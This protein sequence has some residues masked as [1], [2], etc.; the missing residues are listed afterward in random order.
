M[1]NFLPKLETALKNGAVVVIGYRGIKN[2]LVDALDSLNAARAEV[3][4]RAKS[5]LPKTQE[6]LH[7]SEE[8][9]RHAVVLLGII[10]VGDRLYVLVQDST[11]G[12]GFRSDGFRE[13]QPR[14]WPLE[15]LNRPSVVGAYIISN[16]KLKH[17]K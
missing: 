17:R 16:P 7:S 6:Q 1:P 5:M 3:Y 13:I 12:D 9:D 4:S 8:N 11:I 10:E 15:I 14:L 2:G